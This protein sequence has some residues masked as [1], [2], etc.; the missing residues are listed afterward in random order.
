LRIFGLILC[1][2]LLIGL[3][4]TMLMDRFRRLE[5]MIFLLGVLIWPLVLPTAIILGLR[6]FRRRHRS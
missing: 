1:S 5:P 6:D 4:V 2:H 3:L